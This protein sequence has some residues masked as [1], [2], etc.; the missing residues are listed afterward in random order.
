MGVNCEEELHLAINSGATCVL[1]DR[2][3]WLTSYIKEHNLK[4]QKIHI[5]N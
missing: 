2:V 3:H 1:T 5:D 4:F